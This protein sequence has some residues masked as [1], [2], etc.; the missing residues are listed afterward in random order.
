MLEA[1]L[2]A[3]DVEER[4]DVSFRRNISSRDMQM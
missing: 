1:T 2:G 4:M 3:R